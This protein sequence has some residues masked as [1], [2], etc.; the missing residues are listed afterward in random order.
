MVSSFNPQPDPRLRYDSA[1]N[2]VRLPTYQDLESTRQ[3]YQKSFVDGAAQ[4]IQRQ[5]FKA[6]NHVPSKARYVPDALKNTSPDYVPSSRGSGIIPAGKSSGN[7]PSTNHLSKLPSLPGSSVRGDL[8]RFASE[9]SNTKLG[10]LAGK[11]GKLLGPIGGVLAA[12]QAAKNL[13]NPNISKGP[14]TAFQDMAKARNA[15]DFYQKRRDRA[16]A[17]EK[18]DAD[19]Q[20]GEIND[21]FAPA[22]NRN[23]QRDPRKNPGIPPE[24][25]PQGNP[26]PFPDPPMGQE[27]VKGTF[28]LNWTYSYHYGDPSQAESDR[29]GSTVIN[30]WGPVSVSHSHSSPYLTIHVLSYGDGAAPTSTP[31]TTSSTVALVGLFQTGVSVFFSGQQSAPQIPPT[32]AP[33]PGITPIPESIALIP[34][35][36]PQPTATPPKTPAPAPNGEK[37]PT[38]SP[39]SPSKSPDGTPT[40]AP[41]PTPKPP[42]DSAPKPP[43]LPNPTNPSDPKSPPFPQAPIIPL[44][45][46]VGPPGGNP[47]PQE[48]GSPC[49][50]PCQRALQKGI[51]SN[52]SKLDALN[53]ALNGIDVGASAAILSKLDLLDAKLGPQLPGGGISGF[54]KKTWNFLQVDRAL[55][56]MTW[57][58]VVHNAYML[59]N[60]IAQTLFS[61]ISNGLA[62]GG[63]TDADD[64]PLDIGEIV[65]K[66]T[67]NFFKGLF[68]VET[69]DGIKTT[70]KKL[71]RI[72]SSATALLQSIQ[73]IGYS[74][75]QSLE[76]VGQWVAQIGNAVRKYGVVWEKAF[77]WMNPNI[78]FTQNRFFNALNKTQDAVEGVD[79]ITSELLS[80][81]ETSAELSKQVSDLGKALQGKDAEGNS[82]D[83]PTPAEHTKTK[84][85]EDANKS[86]SQGATI[87]AGDEKK[88]ES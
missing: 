21:P 41:A 11:A 30:H 75:L 57:I 76:V 34:S 28:G 10:Q 80:V 55:N 87:N 67:D 29:P 7:L 42:Q 49:Q 85:D 45:M 46:P 53:A 1:G 25:D 19:E 22:N 77:N 12:N 48:P 47:P 82:L 79:E 60:N 3:Q 13:A 71:N 17:G 2:P 84:D 5:Q 81:R 78:N 18:L 52:S 73:S 63:I 39:A 66:W 20:P 6:D 62:V 86:A 14:S 24:L 35:A 27:G 83:K 43:A 37:P 61:A 33:S 74:I 56:I 26:P 72:I 38:E 50:T 58:G 32:P 88:P 68:G 4:D 23:G 51:E 44:P 65:T 54:L 40:P 69:W 59:S 9:L 31:V 16:K 15:S 70:W 8:Q 64:N 36:I